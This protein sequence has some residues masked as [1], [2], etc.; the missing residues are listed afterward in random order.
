M[1][2]PVE[3]TKRRFVLTLV[4]SPDL[5]EVVLLHKL[6]GPALVRGR[7]NF[8]GGGIEPG[9]DALTAGSREDVEETGLVIPE[10]AWS[11]LDFRDFGDAELTTLVAVSPD[12]HRARSCTDE[13]VFVKPV[14]EVRALAEQN[15]DS[16]ANGF[17]HLLD[18]GVAVLTAQGHGPAHHG[19]AS[20]RRSLR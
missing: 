15:P 20:P 19:T 12:W 6:R 9:E 7:T 16:Y 2:V 1:N 8:P 10:T 13:P 3:T 11:V 18:A 14:A 5:T 17:L 4:F